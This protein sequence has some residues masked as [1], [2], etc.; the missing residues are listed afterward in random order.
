MSI[1]HPTDAALETMRAALTQFGYEFELHDWREN[2]RV[3]RRD[4]RSNRSERVATISRKS[5]G[6]QSGLQAKIVYLRESA[7]LLRLASPQV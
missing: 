3:W 7:E 6:T 1:P 4:P 5:V 2:V